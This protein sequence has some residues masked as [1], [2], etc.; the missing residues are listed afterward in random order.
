MKK[1]NWPWLAVL[2]ITFILISSGGCGGGGGGDS[3]GSGGG[4]NGNIISS[5]I[6]GTWEI[7]SG[8]ELVYTNTTNNT[9]SATYTFDVTTASAKSFDIRLEEAPNNPNLVNMLF[10]GTGVQYNLSVSITMYDDIYDPGHN[11]PIIGGSV[12]GFV[13]GARTNAP[14]DN[15]EFSAYSSG[16]S[17]GFNNTTT[18]YRL[19]D[20]NTLSYYFKMMQPPNIIVW[21]TKAILTRVP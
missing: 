12:D 19:I 10:S 17:T 1:N 13:Q 9:L 16:S 15:E 6:N 11:W 4:G 20:H 2:L 5:D 21:E 3:T 18:I 7:A 8:E 14:T